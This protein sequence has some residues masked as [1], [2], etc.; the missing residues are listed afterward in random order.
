MALRAEHTSPAHPFRSHFLTLPTCWAADCP[1]WACTCLLFSQSSKLNAL[2]GGF[3]QG[4]RPPKIPSVRS[5]EGS[6]GVNFDRALA[7]DTPKYKYH[8]TQVPKMVPMV[9]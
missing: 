2:V 4:H 1:Q 5:W 8:T 7:L 9:V 6:G 3:D